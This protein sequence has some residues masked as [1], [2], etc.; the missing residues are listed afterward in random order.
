MLTDT[1]DPAPL[2]TIAVHAATPQ[3]A[4]ALT[5]RATATFVAYVRTRQ[6]AA[7]IARSDRIKLQV[8][9]EASR[10]GLA[11]PR[12]RTLAI[13]VFLATLSF[14]VG[15][16]YVLETTRL[17]RQAARPVKPVGQEPEQEPEPAGEALTSR[18]WA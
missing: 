2:L 1:G 14:A 10:P 7:G 3:K 6:T 18:R 4:L 8:V 5:R 12:K 16:V 9:Q 13:V 15:L 17:R 11:A